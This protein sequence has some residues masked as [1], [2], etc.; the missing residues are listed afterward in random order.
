MNNWKKGMT[1]LLAA[2]LTLVFLTSCGGGSASRSSSRRNSR[3]AAD[4]PVSSGPPAQAGSI[5]REVIDLAGMNNGQLK[6]L[7][8]DACYVYLYYGGTPVV[9]YLEYDVAYPFTFIL[10]NDGDWEAAQEQMGNARPDGNAG[11]GVNPFSDEWPVQYFSFG[12][13]QAHILFGMEGPLT[14]EQVNECFAQTPELIY[15]PYEEGEMEDTEE[16][17]WAV[18]TYEGTFVRIIFDPV[19][20]GYQLRYAAVTVYAEIFG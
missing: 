11:D 9:S 7:L 10:D 18:Y 19:D 1:L 4:D 5:N 3:S 2:C 17:Y 14:F 6:E 16:H 8:G 12:A 15:V 13:E 20:G